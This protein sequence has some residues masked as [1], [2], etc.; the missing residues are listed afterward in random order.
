MLLV[1]LL[2]VTT[3]LIHIPTINCKCGEV[4]KT[5]YT[6]A[7][8]NTVVLLTSLTQSQSGN[9]YNAIN[10]NW[11]KLIRW[12]VLHAKLIQLL[13]VNVCNTNEVLV[14]SIT[15]IYLDKT[16]RNATVVMS[17]LSPELT[18]LAAALLSPLPIR[19]VPYFHED[20]HPLFLTENPK[21]TPVNNE[22]DRSHHL[23]LLIAMKHEYFGV[24]ELCTEKTRC[25]EINVDVIEKHK[26][27]VK[28]KSIITTQ[29]D[30]T[31][32]LQQ[33]LNSTKDNMFRLVYTNGAQLFKP[34]IRQK[35]FDIVLSTNNKVFGQLLYNKKTTCKALIESTLNITVFNQTCTVEIKKDISYDFNIYLRMIYAIYGKIV[36][37]PSWI[38]VLEDYQDN[39]TNFQSSCH[40]PHCRSGKRL[41][42][43]N[44]TQGSRWDSSYDWYCELCPG[45]TF[46]RME[47]SICQPCPLEL[48]S[49]PEK[50]F[51][52]DPNTTSYLDLTDNAAIV[53]L[54]LSSLG[55]FFHAAALA[56][57]IQRRQSPLVLSSQPL[58]LYLQFISWLI[59]Q[60]MVP[61]LFI[62]T[63]HRSICILRPI[64]IGVFLVTPVAT[65]LSKTQ[66]ILTIFAYKTKATK[67]EIRK[68][69]T[70]QIFFVILLISI[71]ACILVITFKN[72]KVQQESHLFKSERVRYQ[73]CNSNIHIQ[74]QFFYLFMLFIG[75]TILGIRARRLPGYFKETNNITLASF[76]CSIILGCSSLV[77][78][79]QDNAKRKDLILMYTIISTNFLYCVI[80]YGYKLFIILFHPDLNKRTVVRNQMVKKMDLR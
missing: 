14:D 12:V 67:R 75:N 64:L 34:S 58:M 31:K 21:V 26:L 69:N 61:L 52:I 68:T 41:K 73:H 2:L 63:P 10:L 17:I 65:T 72:K 36:R 39:I 43:G 62:G 32:E 16:F 3:T 79:S 56:I 5:S 25:Q 49:N 46:K 9:I 7:T 54:V 20:I 76:S 55:F 35:I 11:L 40:I 29:P 24:I 80:L 37:F 42:F 78:F 30:I 4:Y 27:C 59:L 48:H 44:L 8:K 77:Y 53:F 71:A 23:K 47:D 15:K 6:N 50:T 66:K 33:L 13:T 28:Q 19:Y 38:A 45:N 18:R 60:L 51:C 57:F 70:I 22:V 1:A 74:Y